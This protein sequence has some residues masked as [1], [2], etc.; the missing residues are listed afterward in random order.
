MKRIG[1]LLERIADLEN[2]RHA[3]YAASQGKRAKADVIAYRAQA[4]IHLSR[5]RD[6][7][8]EG[9]VPVGSYRQFKVYEPKERVITVAPF[10][11][12]VLHHAIMQVC[13]PVFE[14]Q[15]IDHSYACRKGKGRIAALDAAERFGRSHGYFLKMDIRKYFDSVDHA[16]LKA[17]LR[18]LFKDKALLLLLDG[19]I[20]SFCAQPG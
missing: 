13:E 17:H 10:G 5:L 1:H 16:I 14:R 9:R 20:D 19:I 8:L 2:L 18:R 6:D 12:R 7:L 4:M 15:L 3:L 11:Q